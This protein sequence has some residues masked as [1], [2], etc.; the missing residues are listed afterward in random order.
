MLQQILNDMYIDPELLAELPED[1]KQYLFDKMR[2]VTY[3]FQVFF[4]NL[5]TNSW[6]YCSSLLGA[7]S[8]MVRAR[9]GTGEREREW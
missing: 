1:Q 2:E 6:L 5:F 7:S 4:V 9:K 8:Q 3:F